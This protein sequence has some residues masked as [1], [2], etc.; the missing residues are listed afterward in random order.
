[1]EWCTRKHISSQVGRSRKR[2]IAPDHDRCHSKGYF[3]VKNCVMQQ[4]LFRFDPCIFLSN[5]FGHAKLSCVPRHRYLVRFGGAIASVYVQRTLCVHVCEFVQ[6]CVFVC[7]CMQAGVSV[8]M[9]EPSPSRPKL[10]FVLHFHSSRFARSDFLDAF[11]HLYKRVCP[12]VRPSIRR[13][14]SS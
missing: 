14:R 8:S 1:M 6:V 10:E 3:C 12:T 13:S 7:V 2:D 4:M 11:S 9:Y 5:N